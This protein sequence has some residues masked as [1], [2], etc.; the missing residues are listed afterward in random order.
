MGSLVVTPYK[1]MKKPEE[2]SY[3]VERNFN[4]VG[5]M[6]DFW[7][8]EGRI[9]GKFSREPL[10]EMMVYSR[11]PILSD[12][13]PS[14]TSIVTRMFVNFLDSKILNLQNKVRLPVL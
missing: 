11:G 2:P 4:G 5:Q 1:E 14:K 7:P 8:V 12:L 6:P 10:Y 3:D 13:Y 9:Y